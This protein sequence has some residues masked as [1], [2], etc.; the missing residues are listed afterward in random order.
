MSAGDFADVYGQSSYADTYDCVATCFFL[1][2][3][4]NIIEFVDIIHRI[5]KVCSK[6][7]LR[8][9]WSIHVPI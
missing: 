6:T 3:A 4:H 9:N 8:P 2:C 5:L 1:D 7:A